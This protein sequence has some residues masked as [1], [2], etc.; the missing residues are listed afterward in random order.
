MRPQC[1]SKQGRQGGYKVPNVMHAMMAAVFEQLG[2]TCKAVP[3]VRAV[4][5]T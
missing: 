4:R 2:A 5:L 1:S 3:C